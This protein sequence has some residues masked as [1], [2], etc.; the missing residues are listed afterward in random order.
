MLD[1][2]HQTRIGA[3]EDALRLLG[4]QIAAEVRLAA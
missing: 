1:L 4:K 3:L 2:D